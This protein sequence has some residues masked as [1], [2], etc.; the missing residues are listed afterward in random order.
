MYQSSDLPDGIE[1]A[2]SRLVMGGIN[3]S[4]VRIF[5]KCLLDDL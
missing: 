2:G 1:Q 4:N 3:Q 5:L